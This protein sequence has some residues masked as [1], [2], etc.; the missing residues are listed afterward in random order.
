MPTVVGVRLRNA[1]T[2]SWFDP[3]GH[4]PAVGS[5]VIVR[6]D[7]G[8]EIGRVTEAAHFV[9]PNEVTSTP[10]RIL[11]EAED[12]D[13]AQAE[14]IVDLERDA[15]R[16][17]REL[18]EARELDMKPVEAEYQFDGSRVVLYFVAE[19]RVD[20]RELVKELSSRLKTR[21]DMR[22]VGVRDEAR[23][24]G[25]IGHCGEVLCCARMGGEFQP[26][27]IRMAKEQD[28][29]LNPLKISGRCGRLMCCL[30]Y[31]YDAYKDFKGRAP[32][33]GAQVETPAGSAKVTDLNTPREV[34]TM[35]LGDGTEL[36]VPIERMECGSGKGCPCA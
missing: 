17:L 28:L 31:E 5:A 4:E 9:E 14:R 12:A 7:R 11:R 27:S 22:Q 36:K 13:L 18:V 3:S 2:S 21:I 16:V 8:E 30:R 29:P 10:P 35:R 6:L 25:G 34:V 23:M 1:A 33:R 19:E 32:K 15:V 24:V 26:V 20:F